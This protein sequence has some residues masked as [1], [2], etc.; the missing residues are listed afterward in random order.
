MFGMIIGMTVLLLCFD[1]II[2]HS[3]SRAMFNQFDAGLESAARIMSATV[4][5]DH[6]EIDFEINTELIPE[7]AGSSKTAYYEFW[8]TDGTVIKKSPALGNENLIWIKPFHKHI[9]KTFKMKGDRIFRAAAITFFPSVE[10]ANSDAN[11]MASQSYVLTVARDAHSLLSHLEYLKYL[12]FFASTCIIAVSSAVAV[13]VVKSGLKPLSQLASQI[14]NIKENN[15]KTQI[16]G[17]DLPSEILP[18]KTRLN[19]LLERLEKL[20]EHERT[21]N[22]NVAH[23]L[24]TPIAGLRSIMDV[25]LT[26]NRNAD[27][28]RTALTESLAVIN[29]MEDMIDKLL[30]LAKIENGQITSTYELINFFDLVEKCWKPFVEKAVAR[31]IIFENHLNN[32]LVWKSDEAGLSIIFSNLLNNAIE[33]TNQDGRIWVSS[34]KSDT[35]IELI[36]EN[37]GNILTPQQVKSVFDYY[38]RGD[39]ARSNAGAHSGLGLALVKRIVVLLGGTIQ[40]DTLNGLFS[41]RISLPLN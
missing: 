32:N 15:L 33:Y 24:R 19:S 6:N 17:E 9:F 16:T 31:G 21:F 34:H 35:G 25:A 40:A 12:L 39:S 41:I 28:Y 30:M 38:W 2:Y 26:R 11:M 4:E 20:F 23:E 1:I 27:E 37:S 22:A 13:I 3:I 14:A 10:E 8:K 29:D 7:F 36:F 18:I 5:M